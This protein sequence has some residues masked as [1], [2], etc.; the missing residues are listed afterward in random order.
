[1]TG[2]RKALSNASTQDL[3]STSLRG[4]RQYHKSKLGNL[5]IDG[6]KFRK[7]VR[8]KINLHDITRVQKGIADAYKKLRK[9]TSLNKATYKALTETHGRFYSIMNDGI[10]KFPQEFN[11]VF[12]RI[13]DFNFEVSNLPWSFNKIRGGINGFKE[14]GST[15]FTDDPWN[16]Q[17][18]VRL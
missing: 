5:E 9:S 3:Y 1:M 8:V 12:V 15:T 17:V 16:H 13:I 18:Q 2:A 10:Q 7:P 6:K 4:I 14:I 11:G